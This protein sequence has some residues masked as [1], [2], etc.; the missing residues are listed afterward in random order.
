[1]KPETHVGRDPPTLSVPLTE[2]LVMSLGFAG[3][4]RG[5]GGEW[6]IG[7]GGSEAMGRYGCEWP[8]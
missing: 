7:G 1:M 3:L 2:A 5:R 4:A 8:V 6:G